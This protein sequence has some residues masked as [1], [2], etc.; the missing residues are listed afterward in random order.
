MTV[1]AGKTCLCR[2]CL[3]AAILAK[4]VEHLSETALLAAAFRA[5]ESAR[6]DALFSDPFARMLAGDRGAALLR[7]AKGTALWEF[8]IAVRTRVIDDLL[9]GAFA[10]NPIDVVMN[11][12]AGL[13]A[14]PYRLT[15]PPHVRW[16]EVDDAAILDYKRRILAGFRPQCALEWIADDITDGSGR[17][18]SASD[19]RSTMVITEGVL[20]YLAREDVA[21]IARTLRDARVR[22]WILDH[23]TTIHLDLIAR[24][25]NLPESDLPLGERFAPQDVGAF[26]APYGWTLA[27]EYR[28]ADSAA[29]LGRIVPRSAIEELIPYLPPSGFGDGGYANSGY[30]LLF[31]EDV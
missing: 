12:G 24:A 30:A 10:E 28:H 19:G 16:I 1:D 20:G 21:A 14:R 7:S 4:P 9:F 5:N 23:P 8:A 22:W 25:W 18:R 3:D 13:D 11:L 2:S 26:F 31:R 27:R 29:A 6:A 15:I 17:W